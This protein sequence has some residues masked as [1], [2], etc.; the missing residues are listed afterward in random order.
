MRMATGKTSVKEKLGGGRPCAGLSKPNAKLSKS[1]CDDL[2]LQGKW[3]GIN[4]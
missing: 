2:G 1:S 3:N 4:Y